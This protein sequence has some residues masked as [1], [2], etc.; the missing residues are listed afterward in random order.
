M[1]SVVENNL[2]LIFY[3]YVRARIYISRLSILQKFIVS[4]IHEIIF[5]KLL[6]ETLGLFNICNDRTL[7][8][9]TIVLRL[10]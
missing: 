2:I 10:R 5:C 3:L 7:F 6:S 9:V 1:I 4:Q 8:E